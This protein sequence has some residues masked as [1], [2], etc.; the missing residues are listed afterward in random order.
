MLPTH[1]PSCGEQLAVDRDTRRRSIRCPRCERNV[2]D[3][4]ALR[5]A[6]KDKDD[7]PRRPRKRGPRVLVILGIVFGSLFFVCG[8]SCGMIWYFMVHEIDEPVT[9]ADKEVIA[10][11]EYVAGF[12]DD[13]EA[14]PKK[15]EYHK[16]RHHDG[17][18]ELIYEYTKPDDA[19]EPLYVNHHVFVE[20][21]AKDA[22]EGFAVEQLADKLG[23]NRADGVQE[24][25]RNDL[26]KWGDRSR[27]ILLQSG[28]KPFGQIFVGLK[29][30]RYFTLTISGGYFTD[31]EAIKT[32]IDPLLKKLENYNP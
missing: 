5:F 10:T 28:G 3:S 29:G 23:A 32:F 30:K 1:C 19:N 15:G 24:V 20:R 7:R 4:D 11:G 2:I 18:R 17:S 8:G 22:S 21:S 13:I 14:D 31:A 9:A 25:E 27:C 6:R 12:L 26:W 16:V